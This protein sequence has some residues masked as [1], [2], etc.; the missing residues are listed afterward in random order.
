MKKTKVAWV[1]TASHNIY[2]WWIYF[3]N[4][5]FNL[6]VY[7]DTSEEYKNV[8]NR[9]KVIQKLKRKLFGG[10]D[11]ILL[12]DPVSHKSEYKFI[13]IWEIFINLLAFK[14]IFYKNSLFYSEFFF[15]NSDS[16]FKKILFHIWT[17]SFRKKKIIVPTMHSY[18]SFQKISNNVLYF[19]QIYYWNIYKNQ[20]LQNKKLKILFVWNL[21]WKTKNLDFLLNTLTH[22]KNN[23]IEIWLCGRIDW[24]DS[25]LDMYKEI[26]GKKLKYYWFLW[27]QELS[28]VYLQ[29]NLFVLPSTWDAIGSVVI[30]AMAHSLPVIVSENVWA[31]SYIVNKKNGF[32]FE[33]NNTKD[34][35]EKIQYLLDTEKRQEF[36]E[37][38]YEL[39][40]KLYWWKNKKLLKEKKDEIV[41]FTIPNSQ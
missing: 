17:F 30:E 13:I 37:Y 33:N 3:L 2:K 16:F 19:P 5:N 36:W 41:K 38:S 11:I 24:F 25:K 6:D 39:V 27:E 35:L 10:N 34:L 21:W 12:Q 7:D 32:I 28:N 29:H 31:S 20:N 4:E 15:K 26:F 1:L 14:Y 22:I 18:N 9:I 23:N 40:Q 8:K